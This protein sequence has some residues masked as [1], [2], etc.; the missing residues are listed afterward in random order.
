LHG[1]YWTGNQ[2]ILIILVLFLCFE[3]ILFHFFIIYLV[4]I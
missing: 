4:E 2:I 3:H 1:L